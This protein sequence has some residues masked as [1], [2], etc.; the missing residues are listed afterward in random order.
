M[1]FKEKKTTS[2]LFIKRISLNIIQ[3][4]NSSFTETLFTEK[5]IAKSCNRLWEK[6]CKLEIFYYK[7]H[8]VDNNSDEMPAFTPTYEMTHSARILILFFF[9]KVFLTRR[10]L[11]IIVASVSMQLHQPLD[12][13]AWT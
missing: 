13:S 11:R 10:I 7:F 8:R 2:Y 5:F 4:K 12:D 3:E 9:W 6:H 1:R